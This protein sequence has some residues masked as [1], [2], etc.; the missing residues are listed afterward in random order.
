MP[1]AA[2]VDTFEAVSAIG[3]RLDK[4]SLF[5]TLFAA[6]IKSKPTELD[7]VVHLASNSLGPAYEGLELGIGDALLIKAICEGILKTLL[8]LHLDYIV[9]LYFMYIATG[10]T[11]S[12][13]DDDYGREGDLG[14]VALASR[15][16]QKTLSFAAKPKPLSV[17]FVFDQLRQIALTKVNGF[18][19][20]LLKS[21]NL[22]LIKY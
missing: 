13:V 5:R 11:K 7:Y 19:L 22:Q 4:E 3:G 18:N 21:V 17:P 9:W 20:F 14:I 1:Y 6:V 16:S 2:L 15:S 12:A 10:R 8:Y